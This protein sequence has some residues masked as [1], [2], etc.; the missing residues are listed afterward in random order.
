M[1]RTAVR[2]QKGISFGIRVDYKA[3]RTGL[4]GRQ[5]SVAYPVSATASPHWSQGSGYEF[6]LQTGPKLSKILVDV[7]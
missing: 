4:N 7:S 1:R 6:R 2:V 5:E 3:F